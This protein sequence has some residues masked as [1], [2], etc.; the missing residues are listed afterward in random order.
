MTEQEARRRKL[1]WLIARVAEADRQLST[2]LPEALWRDDTGIE[3][4]FRAS[5]ASVRDLLGLLRRILA[6]VGSSKPD[7]Q[8]GPPV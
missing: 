5:W 2:A 7:E 3:V 4:D 6:C 1:A 8:D